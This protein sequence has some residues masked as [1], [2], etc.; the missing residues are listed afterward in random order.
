MKR[1][2]RKSKKVKSLIGKLLNLFRWI[3]DTN[4]KKMEK[5]VKH[6]CATSDLILNVKSRRP[7]FK[8]GAD[9]SKAVNLVDLDWDES[10]EGEHMVLDL[11]LHLRSE[12][13]IVK[14]DSASTTSK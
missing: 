3:L 2:V 11:K 6:D 8:A 10:I 5:A 1:T 9:L 14:G 13:C 4:C 7:R 12:G